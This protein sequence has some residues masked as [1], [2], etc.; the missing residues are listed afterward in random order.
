MSVSEVDEA[1]LD[2][3]QTAFAVLFVVDEYQVELAA[4]PSG[5]ERRLASTDVTVLVLANSEA[6]ASM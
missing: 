2:A 4:A 1:T 6:Q 3:L 5:T